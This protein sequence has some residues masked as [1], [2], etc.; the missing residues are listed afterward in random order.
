M[1]LQETYD[2]SKLYEERE[3]GERHVKYQP[4][5]HLAPWDAYVI[6]FQYT[7]IHGVVSP[8]SEFH[9]NITNG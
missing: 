7:V 9:S 2:I 3:K 5:Q 1:I 6:K 4:H 8:I